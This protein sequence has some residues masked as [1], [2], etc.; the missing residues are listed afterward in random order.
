MVQAMSW[1]DTLLGK[2]RSIHAEIAALQT[3]LGSAEEGT[4]SLPPER[5]EAAFANHYAMLDDLYLRQSPF[6]RA[7]E[8]SDLF[9]NYRSA[10]GHDAAGERAG[11]GTVDRLFGNV[12]TQVATMTRAVIGSRDTEPETPGAPGRKEPELT[13]SAY[14]PGSYVGFLVP[15]AGTASP[16]QAE[17]MRQ[18]LYNLGRV[19]HALPEKSAPE[20]IATAIDDPEVR[21]A[22]LGA[23]KKLLPYRDKSVDAIELRGRALDLT[24]PAA[25][26]RQTWQIADRLMVHPVASAERGVFTGHI[27]QI[28]YELCRFELRWLDDPRLGN[29][30]CA[31]SAALAQACEQAVKRKVE[32]EGAV[33]FRRGRPRLVH[34]ESIR[35]ID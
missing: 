17:A 34:V 5:L 4:P 23:V 2:A 6:A 29:I 1:L 30:R 22:T 9:L 33:D 14:L 24:L 11:L 21:D 31:Y 3:Y 27:L 25:I 15:E 10:A 13:V 18:S 16:G 12:R 8:T 28:D 32:V 7:A 35:L 26:D 19:A 20:Q